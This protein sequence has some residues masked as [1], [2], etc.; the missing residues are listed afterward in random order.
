MSPAFETCKSYHLAVNNVLFCWNVSEQWLLSLCC[1]QTMGRWHQLH[2]WERPPGN[3]EGER[4][5]K[6]SSKEMDWDCCQLRVLLRMEGQ[7]RLGPGWGD[8]V[9]VFLHRGEVGRGARWGLG[10]Q[11]WHR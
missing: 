7:T 11:H 1:G 5:W 4:C 2:A 9:G 3:F 6:F 10:P 8:G